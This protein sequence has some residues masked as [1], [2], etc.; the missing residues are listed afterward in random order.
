MKHTIRVSALLACLVAPAALAAPV[1]YKVDSRHTYP[2]FQADHGGGMSFWRGKFNSTSGRI[3][4]D[5]RPAPARWT[6]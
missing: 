1:Q 4:L 6:S 5:K 2:S 3:V